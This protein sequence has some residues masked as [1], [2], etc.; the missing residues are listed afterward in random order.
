MRKV[1]CDLCGTLINLIIS[2][3]STFRTQPD[4]KDFHNGFFVQEK[5]EGEVC[6]IC[7]ERLSTAVDQEIKKI[8][9]EFENETEERKDA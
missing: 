4:Y 8:K 2:W 3:T 7:H 6:P 9:E 5:T 1:Y